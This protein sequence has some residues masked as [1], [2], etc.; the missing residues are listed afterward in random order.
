MVPAV[1]DFFSISQYFTFLF[2]T[3]RA[4]KRAGEKKGKKEE[5]KRGNTF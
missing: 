5:K 3:R 4:E 2:K 1:R